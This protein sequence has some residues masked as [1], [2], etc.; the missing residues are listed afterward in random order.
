[1][2]RWT[3][4]SR[5]RSPGQSPT[6]RYRARYR[7]RLGGLLRWIQHLR[8]LVLLVR[9][10]RS[11]LLRALLVGNWIEAVGAVFVLAE[12]GVWAASSMWSRRGLMILL[13]PK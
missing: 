5:S 1:M 7:A 11:G 8:Q 4:S 10:L 9:V 3:G 2:S 6:L 12:M 13:P